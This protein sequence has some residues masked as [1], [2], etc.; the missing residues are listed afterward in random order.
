VDWHEI[1]GRLISGREDG[2]A[3][4]ALE[5]RVWAWAFPELWDRGR[6]VVD[7]VVAGTCAAV[8]AGLAGAYGPETFA[9]FVR[10]HYLDARRRAL[11]AGWRPEAPPSSWTDVP[12]PAPG[13]RPPPVREELGA[14]RSCLEA[15]PPRQ[16][17]AVRLRYVEGRPLAEVAV[18]L[19]V[20][21]TIAQR[22]LC[23]GVAQLR[24]GLP[25]AVPAPGGGRICPVEATARA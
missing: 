10:G 5:R 23:L 22:I 19:G 1:Y 20:D 25:A 24:R 3:W 15:L 2:P 9:G 18:A 11:R 7:D 4:D 8:V 16:R 14:L 6:R 17:A 12:A 21:E 13:S